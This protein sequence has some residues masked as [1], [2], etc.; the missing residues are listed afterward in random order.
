MQSVS[1]FF[2]SEHLEV[3]TTRI[4]FL[5]ACERMVIFLLKL[6]LVSPWKRLFSFVYIP[7]CLLLQLEFEFFCL[8][9]FLYFGPHNFVSLAGKFP[10][11]LVSTCS[12][13]ENSTWQQLFWLFV[14]LYCFSLW[15]RALFSFRSSSDLFF[16]K[17]FFYMVLSITPFKALRL[18]WYHRAIFVCPTSIILWV[19]NFL[20]HC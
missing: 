8:L 17:D 18:L 14:G 20:N 1:V 3:D 7:L 15:K 11:C 10:K 13:F 19:T 4:T 2:L 16:N 6:E 12:I 9:L 5:P